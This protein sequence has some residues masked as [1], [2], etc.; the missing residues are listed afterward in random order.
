MKQSINLQLWLNSSECGKFSTA[1]PDKIF[2]VFEKFVVFLT[3]YSFIVG[4][5]T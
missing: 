5:V 2:L 4:L 3:F 1:F